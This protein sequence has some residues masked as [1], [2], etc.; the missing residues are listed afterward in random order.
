MGPPH[1]AD[2]GDAQTVV[3]MLVTDRRR[4]SPSATGPEA[5]DAL[6]NLV[7]AA[8]RAGIDVIH[9]RE[10][11]LE[12]RSLVSLVRRCVIAVEGS[13]TRVLVNDRA[14][15]ALAAGADGVHLRADSIDAATVRRLMPSGSLLGRSVHTNDGA[16][17]QGGDL[18]YVVFGTM[19][20]TES[21]PSWQPRASLD[22]LATLCGASPIPVLAIGGMTLERARDAA[23]A[24]AAGVAAIGLFIP[25]AGESARTH[26][27]RVTAD[28][29]RTFDTCQAVS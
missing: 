18:D 28:L 1:N 23:R 13:R 25:P 21:K 7:D 19:F 10:R 4:L 26:L 3:I 27:D 5:L 22:D 20:Q 17:A 24:G 14:D 2:D 16:E 9:I 11:D 12:T 8:A 6:I 29:R 15:V